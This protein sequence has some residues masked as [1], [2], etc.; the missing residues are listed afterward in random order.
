MERSHFRKNGSKILLITRLVHVFLQHTNLERL[1]GHFMHPCASKEYN[2]LR[3][4]HPDELQ[5]DILDVLKMN[6]EKFETCQIF[7]ARQIRFSVTLGNIILKH[8]L[9]LH[10]IYIYTIANCETPVLHNI[11]DGTH[12]QSTRFLKR[13]NTKT[14]WETI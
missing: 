8:K 4:G 9:L 14:L 7:G 11:E 6:S 10:V 13:N 12:Y 3:R 2:L 1:H 5:D